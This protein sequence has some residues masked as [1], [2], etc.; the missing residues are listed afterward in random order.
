MQHPSLGQSDGLWPSME[1]QRCLLHMLALWQGAHLAS[2]ANL[3]LQKL[4]FPRPLSTGIPYDAT[5]LQFCLCLILPPEG[6]CRCCLVVHSFRQ[7]TVWRSAHASRALPASWGCYLNSDLQIGPA[8]ELLVDCSNCLPLD[9]S[10][11]TSRCGSLTSN[12][13]PFSLSQKGFGHRACLALDSSE[14]RFAWGLAM[15]EVMHHSCK[16]A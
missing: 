13:R 7:L 2:C 16:S 5:F 9:Y 12:S 14:P 3:R 6:L 10:N 4:P 15:S 1:R 8:V 11:M